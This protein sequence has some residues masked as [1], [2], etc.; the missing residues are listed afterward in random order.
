MPLLSL[1][2]LQRQ[3]T[4]ATPKFKFKN[5]NHEALSVLQSCN[6]M[7]ELKRV[8]AH[9]ITTGRIRDTYIATKMVESYAVRARNM[10]YAHRVFDRVDDPDS[11][12][13]T[14]LIRGCVLAKN[15]EKAIE[16]YGVMRSRGVQLNKFTFLFVLKAYGLRPSY[17]E[18]R[19]VH[20]KIVKMGFYSDVFIRNALIH[21]YSKCG[22]LSN[23]C[24]LF[25][26][27]PTCNVVNWNTMIMAFFG[28]GDVENGRRLFDEMPE[29]NVESWNAVIGGYSKL[30]SVDIARAL[31]DEMPERDLVS[32]GAMISGYVQNR[33]AME[34][35]ELFNKMQFDGFSPDGVIITSILSGCAQ[36]GALDMGRWIHAYMNTKKLT[37]DVILG[38]SLLD[39]YAKCGC[40]DISFQLFHNMPQKN[41]CSWNAMLSGLAI[42]GHGSTALELFKEMEAAHIEPNDVTFVAVLSACS[43]MG[44]VDEG[45]KQFDRMDTEFHITPKIEHYGCMV[46][47]LGRGG[48]INEAKE[49]IA[50]MPMEPNI[51]IWGALLNACKIHG[52]T[53]INDDVEDYLQKLA[54]GD[55]G[56]YVLLSNIF[57]GKNQWSE[58]EKTRKVMRETQT[59]RKIPGC[60][61]IEVNGVVHEFFAEDRVHPDW[62]EVNEAI[63][64]LRT[65]S[66]IKGYVPNPSLVL[67][68]TDEFII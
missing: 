65:H 20:G 19:V 56:C 15:P 41:L 28:C 57:A 51:V 42:H 14:T 11:Y 35:L 26:E 44:S 24:K 17:E 18:G 40:I 52:Y 13:W 4:N 60:S 30:G 43:H 62:K 6:S 48:L 39:M 45:W 37:N 36:I 58:V 22:D 12:S 31:F 16:F 53:N 47:I 38:T 3:L 68:N 54:L 34:A 23:G 55:G 21:M 7:E 67:Y 27:M 33:R 59:E 32:W 29:R 61:S 2:S 25:D 5:S 66:E 9:L 1:P 49:L 46:D 63:E 10:D 8:H 64:R 50:T